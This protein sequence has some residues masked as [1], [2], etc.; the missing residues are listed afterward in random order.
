MSDERKIS[1]TLKREQIA[2]LER[3][4]DAGD[5]ADS[6]AIV[7]EALRDWQLK[8]DL[9][10]DDIRRLHLLWDAGKKS[11]K[12]RKFDIERTLLAARRRRGKTAAE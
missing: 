7:R 6:G 11:G 2:A 8:R 4:V 1:I 5:Y 10:G 9:H 12:P 3:A